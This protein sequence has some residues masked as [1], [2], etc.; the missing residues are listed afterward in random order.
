MKMYHV[1]FV[2]F[3][4]QQYYH[5]VPFDFEQWI[6]EYISEATIISRYEIKQKRIVVEVVVEKLSQVILLK[7]EW[8]EDIEKI[9]YA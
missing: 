5:V 1:Q 3:R 2:T 4:K 8:S 9:W 6:K 7:L